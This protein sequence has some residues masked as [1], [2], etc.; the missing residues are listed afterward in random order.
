MQAI[1]E[2]QVSRRGSEAVRVPAN[3]RA[4]F[5]EGCAISLSSMI[6]F[7]PIFRF[8]HLLHDSILSDSLK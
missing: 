2:A 1:K 3:P 7:G 8:T 6:A 5:S 4:G